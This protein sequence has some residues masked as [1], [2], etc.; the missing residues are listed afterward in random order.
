MDRRRIKKR[1]AAMAAVMVLVWS[2]G[3]IASVQEE[4]RRDVTAEEG[5]GGVSAA[6]TDV[7]VG[8]SGAS[9]G[10]RTQDI[11]IFEDPGMVREE[12]L[13]Q[14]QAYG[15]LV[16][17]YV[18][19]D[20]FGPANNERVRELTEFLSGHYEVAGRKDREIGRAHV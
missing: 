3:C 10:K 20:S 19:S 1:A 15:A 16:E 8:E 5:N 2:G 4:D 9:L 13:A 14:C 11:L 6:E 7:L 12:V 17:S 18:G